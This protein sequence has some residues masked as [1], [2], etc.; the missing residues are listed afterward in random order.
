MILA[1]FDCVVF[2]QAAAN[3]AG[4]AGGCLDLVEKGDVKLFLSPPILEEARDVFLRPS[5]R[6]KFP[7]LTGEEVDR[8]LL[9][10]ASLSTFVQDV[11]TAPRLSRDPKDEPYLHLAIFSQAAFVVTRDK[12]LLDLMNDDAFLKACPGLAIV[13]PPAFATHVRAE[14]A[15][16]AGE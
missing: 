12:D 16:A 3:P 14:I 2:L 13:T 10:V 1:V 4:P 11:P 8:F 6:K 5:T 9:K 15:N 7:H